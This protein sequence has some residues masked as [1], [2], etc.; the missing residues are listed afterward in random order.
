M[1]MTLVQG[2][3]KGT[4]KQWHVQITQ[5]GLIIARGWEELADELLGCWSPTVGATNASSFLG[6]FEN[7][8]L[9]SGYSD[10][11]T[12]LKGSRFG[13]VTRTGSTVVTHI[14]D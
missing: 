6:L 5:V 13:V 10:S 2:P 12:V 3:G 14:Y 8:K 7:R 11:K 9:K 4:N 1:T